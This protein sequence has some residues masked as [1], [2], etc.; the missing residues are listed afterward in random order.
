MDNLGHFLE[1]ITVHF[2]ILVVVPNEAFQYLTSV[3]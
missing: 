3:H 2:Y 1:G